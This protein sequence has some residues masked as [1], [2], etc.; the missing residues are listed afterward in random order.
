MRTIRLSTGYE[1]QWEGESDENQVAQYEQLLHG[2][3][4]EHI[5]DGAGEFNSD[6]FLPNVMAGIR[7]EIEYLLEEE[8]SDHT[9]FLRQV[10][11]LD[12]LRMWL[13]IAN[14][15]KSGEQSVAGDN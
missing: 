7:K 12:C 10:L 6:E 15:M 11:F 13:H 4:G 1:V 3:I 5:R 14:R 9:K 2:A 8:I